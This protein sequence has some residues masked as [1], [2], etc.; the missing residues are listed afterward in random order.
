MSAARAACPVSA[1]AA[2]HPSSQIRMSFAR[3]SF[4]SNLMR[5]RIVPAM[6]I[7]P[8]GRT[9]GGLSG[10]EL[11]LVPA[12]FLVASRHR[13]LA[14]AGLFPGRYRQRLAVV[15]LVVHAGAVRGDDLHR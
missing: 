4:S 1:I 10:I 8:R 13:D 7:K 12:R 6:A 5:S 3:M 15:H 14:L 11:L 2:T 9:Y